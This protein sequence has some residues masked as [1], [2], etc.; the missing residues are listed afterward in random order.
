M[1]R[2]SFQ[3]SP[4]LSVTL[5]LTFSSLSVPDS[6]LSKAQWHKAILW[7]K[8][9]RGLSYSGID[10]IPVSHLT[11]TQKC[12]KVN[13]IRQRH[14]NNL[15]AAENGFIL[16]F[17]WCPFMI[18]KYKRAGL[19]LTSRDRM[20]VDSTPLR[21]RWTVLK[22]RRKGLQYFLSICQS[23]QIPFRC[24]SQSHQ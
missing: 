4:I 7:D 10:E 18:K 13:L 24:C 3:Q 20:R 17:R 14:L 6:Q 19:Q 16:L 12:R 9:C 22:H 23:L 2:C 21:I 1:L 5:T 8:G 15:K 11:E